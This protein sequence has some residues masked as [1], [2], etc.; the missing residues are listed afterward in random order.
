M[1]NLTIYNGNNGQEI[2]LAGLAD[3]NGTPV[4]A[5]TITATI[6]RAGATLPGSNM[7]FAPVVGTPGSYMAMLGGFDA[8]AGK[9]DLMVSGTNA[10]IAFNFDVFVTIA[11]RSI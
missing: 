8:P 9:A 1:S 3:V 11:S 4:S 7:T 6:T 10:G 5:A 2:V